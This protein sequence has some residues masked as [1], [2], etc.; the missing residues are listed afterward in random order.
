MKICYIFLLSNGDVGP[1][2][3][4]NAV[5]KY[6]PDYISTISNI[7]GDYLFDSKNH[8]KTKSK[9]I[10][11]LNF[12]I[13]SIIKKLIKNKD[14]DIF[15][16]RFSIGYFLPIFYLFLRNQKF[17]IELNGLT[18]QDL[19]DRNKN[20]IIRFINYFIEFIS[21]RLSE[22]LIVVHKNI[23]DVISKRYFIKSNNFS[24]IPNGVEPIDIESVYSSPNKFFTLGYLGSLSKRE[25]VDLLLS[26]FSK[27]DSSVFKLIIVGG[28]QNEF[29]LLSKEHD[30]SNVEYHSNTEYDEAIK[31]INN[32]DCFI[33]LRRPLK[34]KFDSQGSPLKIL[35]YLNLNK[36]IIASNI[37]SYK[38]M[39]ENG[40]G[41]LI[42]PYN[43]ED[44]KSKVN[45]LKNNYSQ[46][47]SINSN[48]Y[49]K[50]YYSW[51]TQILKLRQL[52]Y[53]K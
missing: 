37:S 52:F 47:N 22:K 7:S 43:F 17:Y 49:V 23:I 29:N 46:F 10:L 35:D 32:S 9:N 26:Y 33:H 4:V 21:F 2:K 36:P 15:L 18:F 44:F 51:K 42:N 30:L 50:N 16:V 31:I 28:Q 40:F 41:L 48:Q 8:I 12:E 24:V 11:K 25:G 1:L 14:Q 27:L 3:H 13:I 5:L 45:Y 39:S 6:Y 38:F 34:G 20:F 53:E 19:K